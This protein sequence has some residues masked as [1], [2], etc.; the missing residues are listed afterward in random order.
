MTLTKKFAEGTISET[1]YNKETKACYNRLK[2]LNKIKDDFA[3]ICRKNTPEIFYSTDMSSFK[4]EEQGYTNAYFDKISGFV[5]GA[6]VYFRAGSLSSI[7]H[8]NRHTRQNY[9]LMSKFE[10]EVEAFTYQRM[11][12]AQDVEDRIKGAFSIYQAW[13]VEGRQPKKY[14]IEEMVNDVYVLSK[15]K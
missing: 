13:K 10:R 1:K 8:E 11:F 7:I 4:K 9:K 3:Y 6:K 14:D 2:E 5:S 15:D 12:N